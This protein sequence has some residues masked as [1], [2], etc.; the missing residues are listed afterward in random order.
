MFVLMWE[1]RNAD[2]FLRRNAWYNFTPVDVALA[3][4]MLPCC[5][6][7]QQAPVECSRVLGTP[8]APLRIFP[9]TLNDGGLLH[10]RECCV[11]PPGQSIPPALRVEP[12]CL[13]GCTSCIWE[14]HRYLL[15]RRRA[16]AALRADHRSIAGGLSLPFSR[17]GESCCRSEILGVSPTRK[18]KSI[19]TFV[20]FCCVLRGRSSVYCFCFF[21]SSALWRTLNWLFHRDFNLA[22]VGMWLLF[23]KFG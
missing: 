12:G 7:M 11:A 2:D 14:G 18:E 3:H 6:G 23:I 22:T 1:K 9:L 13:N 15:R 10:I 19:K 20:L 16:A 17:L 5:C 8:V 21:L 4:S